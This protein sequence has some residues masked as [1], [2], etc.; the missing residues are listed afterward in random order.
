MTDI[1]NFENQF[2]RWED[3]AGKPARGE[4]T[5]PKGE[6]ISSLFGLGPMPASKIPAVQALVTESNRLDTRPG[7]GELTLGEQAVRAK[8]VG[9]AEKGLA[10]DVE[11]KVV[12]LIAKLRSLYGQI[13]M[14]DKLI[15]AADIMSLHGPNGELLTPGEAQDAHDTMRDQVTRKIGEGSKEHL[16]DRDYSKA[17]NRRLML[18][19]FPVFLLAMMGLLNVNLRQVFNL[20]GPALVGAGTAIVFAIFGTWLFAEI[21]GR[22]G[23]RHR[24]FKD[25]DTALGAPDSTRK[26]MRAEQIALAAIVI[27]ASSVMG[28]RIFTE[29]MEADTPLALVLTLSGLLAVLVG[30][31]GYLNYMSEYENGSDQTDRVKHLA[32]QLGNREATIQQLGKQRALLVEESGIVLATLHRTLAAAAEA[33]AQKV[34]GSSADKAIRA[35]RSYAGSRTAVPAPAFDSP[36]ILEIERQANELT[37]HHALLN[38]KEN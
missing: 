24:R 34:T 2:A 11:R 7:V 12:P 6:K 38:P 27:F 28:I 16:I 19:D 29:G 25:A 36:T 4:V 30:T 17:R 32:S 13:N 15:G 14:L 23:A 3:P 8:V 35:S 31:A 10:K 5:I 26:R 21:M 33:A 18:L 9:R 1:E 22:S 20:D 37:E